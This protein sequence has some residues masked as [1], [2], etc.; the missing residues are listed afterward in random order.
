MPSVDRI[1]L[2]DNDGDGIYEGTYDKF[3]QDGNYRIVFYGHDMEGD[4]IMSTSRNILVQ[5]GPTDL[6]SKVYL[7]VVTR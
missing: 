3:D 5:L 1:E 2:S 6:S 4:A 7:P